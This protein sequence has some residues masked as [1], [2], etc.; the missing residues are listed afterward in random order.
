MLPI[1]ISEKHIERRKDAKLEKDEHTS[2]K[3]SL[4]SE[5]ILFR[6]KSGNNESPV[7]LP[8][9]IVSGKTLRFLLGFM[10]NQ[11]R[12]QKSSRF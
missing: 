1:D 12:H 7:A 8:V 5:Y 4:H 11:F 10:P 2:T 3:L 6:L 9:P